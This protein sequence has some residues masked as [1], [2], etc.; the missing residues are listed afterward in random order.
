VIPIA[1][2][3]KYVPRV[4]DYEYDSVRVSCPFCGST[5]LHGA[6]D[7][8]RIAHCN[9]YPPGSYEIVGTE[10]ARRGAIVS[11]PYRDDHSLAYQ[12][13]GRRP[14]A[15]L[16]MDDCAETLGQFLQ[17]MGAEE[18][19]VRTMGSADFDSWLDRNVTNLALF[20]GFTKHDVKDIR[21]VASI[22]R[23][24]HGS[25]VLPWHLNR[26]ARS[27]IKRDAHGRA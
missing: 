6:A 16:G 4:F 22:Q 13:K 27:Q 11:N 15:R 2:V 24:L 20:V 25:Y 3:H 12:L 17:S 10:A 14:W 7:G 26:I 1:P 23:V 19:I 8:E 9:R 18:L 5:H 21:D